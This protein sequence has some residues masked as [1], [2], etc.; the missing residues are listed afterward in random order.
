MCLNAVH[1]LSQPNYN[2]I[3]F[4]MVCIKMLFTIGGNKD[5]IVTA[6]Y[7]INSTCFQTTY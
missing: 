7:Q 4:D 2:A 6:H 1:V 3:M 5:Y